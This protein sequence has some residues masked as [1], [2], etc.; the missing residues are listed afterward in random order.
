MYYNKKSFRMV[1]FKIRCLYMNILLHAHH[2]NRLPP[3]PMIRKAFNITID[4]TSQT[5]S[6]ISLSVSSSPTTMTTQPTS[7][8]QQSWYALGAQTYSTITSGLVINEIETIDA[9]W[10]E[11][12]PTNTI[13]NMIID[14]RDNDEEEKE[15]VLTHQQQLYSSLSSFTFGLL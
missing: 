1:L 9:P 12:E 10:A 15:E 7:A 4:E 13:T 6:S 8:N 5:D 3:Y 2:K 14:E 11:T